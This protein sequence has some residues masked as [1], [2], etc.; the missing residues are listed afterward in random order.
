MIETLAVI[1]S[2]VEE[3]V[4]AYDALVSSV[5]AIA[6]SD[7]PTIQKRDRISSVVRSE[8]QNTRLRTADHVKEVSKRSLIE[9][10]DHLLTSDAYA[11]NSVPESYLKTASDAAESFLVAE[12]GSIIERTSN[13]VMREVM[14]AELMRGQ[15]DGSRVV[16]MDTI[17]RRVRSSLVVRKTWRSSLRDHAIILYAARMHVA[18]Q[19]TLRLWNE[20]SMSHHFGRTIDVSAQNFG[21]EDLEGVFHPNSKTVPVHP[22][23]FMEMTK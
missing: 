11:V 6:S 8:V 4:L 2:L 23:K 15:Y 1:E 12:I 18:G 14:R 21:I 9:A 10:V 19:M 20:S 17:G 5:T 7:L 22:T 13:A 16:F 3:A